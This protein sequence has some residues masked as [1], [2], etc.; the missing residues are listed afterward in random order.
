MKAIFVDRDGTVIADPPDFRVN[1]M[2]EVE[3]L[4]HTLPALKLLATLD[5]GILF[6]TNQA[7]IAESLITMEEF[8]TINNKILELIAPSGI[9]ILKTYVCPHSEHDNCDCRKPKPK[10]LLNAAKEF[11]ID[12][13]QS[14]TIGDRETDIQT[15]INAGT[16]TILVETGIKPVSDSTADFIAADLLAAADYIAKQ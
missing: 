15:G 10:M 3:L 1:S 2:S 4:P 12:L 6:V 8:E 13:A 16:K 14:Y 7:G 11:D 9:K 5:F